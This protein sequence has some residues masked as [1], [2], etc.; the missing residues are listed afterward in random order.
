MGGMF[1][2]PKVNT[3]AQQ[4]SID[5]QRQSQDRQDAELKKREE[6]TA[7]AEAGQA[8]SRRARGASGR[9]ALIATGEA[10]LVPYDPAL[11]KTLG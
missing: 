3:Q 10:G 2:K 6:A 5:L 11:Q 1:S 4:D 9:A 7:K 8:A